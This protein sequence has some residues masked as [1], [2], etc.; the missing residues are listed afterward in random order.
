M[1]GLGLRLSLGSTGRG[2]GGPP[3]IPFTHDDNTYWWDFGAVDNTYDAFGTETISVV[4]ERIRGKYDLWQTNKSLQPLKVTGGANF[5]TTTNRV[6]FMGL[7]PK[8]TNSKNG[9]Y[10]AAV[11]KPDTGNSYLLEIARAA[12]T[13]ASRGQAYVTSARNIM[14][15]GNAVDSATVNAIGNTTSQVT[16]GNKIAP[17]IDWDFD[18]DALTMA[19]NGVNQAITAGTELG[20]W[21]AFPATDPLQII[22]GNTSNGG[23][24]FNGTVFEMILQDGVPSAGIKSSISSYV[25]AQA[26]A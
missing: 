3:A 20:P 15:K 13:A 8:I 4:K 18:A 2:G 9:W 10:L 12:S 7:P 22:V 11:I 24:S 17:E 6:M 21:S 14:L 25:T 23:L 19:I 1:L 5:N 16:L 26:A